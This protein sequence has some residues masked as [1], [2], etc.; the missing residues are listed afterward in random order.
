[1]HWAEGSA[2]VSSVCR[3]LR[4]RSSAGGSG[5]QRSRG[6]EGRGERKPAEEEAAATHS[7][8]TILPPPYSPHHPPS[9]ILPPPSSLH[10]PPS[11]I[12]PPP[13]PPNHPPSTIPPP[14]SSLHHPPSTIP[15]PP[16]PLHQ[17]AA[18]GNVLQ[19][20]GADGRNGEERRCSRR[21]RGR[22]ESP[23]HA[24]EVEGGAGKMGG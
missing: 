1:L 7:P 24:G 21:E 3:C 12:L 16:S 5:E 6:G 13:S 20:R 23:E 22:A 17:H 15:P 2:S 8:S 9:T 10:H 19:Q 14:P 18:G 11:T 4:E